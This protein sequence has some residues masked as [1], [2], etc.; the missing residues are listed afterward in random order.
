MD[1]E[2]TFVDGRAEVIAGAD[3]YEQ[4]GPMTTFFQSD[5]RNY[6]DFWSS[7]IASFRTTD[8]IAVR[9]KAGDQRAVF[10]RSK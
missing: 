9:R 6:V 2:L 1:Y 5:G 7:R 8:L 3:S 4:E 10:Q